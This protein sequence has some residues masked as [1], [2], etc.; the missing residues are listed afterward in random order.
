VG[1]DGRTYEKAKSG[2]GCIKDL[3]TILAW[4]EKAFDATYY[5][6]HTYEPGNIEELAPHGVHAE[7]LP[8]TSSLN[9]RRGGK[10]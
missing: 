2:P 8:V 4:D 9:I 1:Y 5:N 7:Y 3:E 10:R 6:T